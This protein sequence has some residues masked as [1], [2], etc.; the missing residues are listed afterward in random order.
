VR[1]GMRVALSQS[2]R[3]RCQARDRRPR[4]RIEATHHPA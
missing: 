4:S 3:Q 1:K 2:S